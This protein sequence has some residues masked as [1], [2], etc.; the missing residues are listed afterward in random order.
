MKL[1]VVLPSLDTLKKIQ[2]LEN[3]FLPVD[4][5]LNRFKWIRFQEPPVVAAQPRRTSPRDR[6]GADHIEIL[7]LSVAKV[8]FRF[9]YQRRA[10]TDNR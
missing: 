8:F 6:E 1:K 3:R 10:F 4:L 5:F 9:P 2:F 7:T